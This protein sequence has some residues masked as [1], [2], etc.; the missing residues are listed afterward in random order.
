[1]ESFY[2]NQSIAKKFSRS[3]NSQVVIW[4]QMLLEKG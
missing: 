3:L 4:M 1:M 2:A